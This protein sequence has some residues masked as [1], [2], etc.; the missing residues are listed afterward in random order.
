MAWVM[1]RLGLY[2]FGL[3]TAAYQE[4]NR[5][6]A[7]RWARQERMGTNDAL[8]FTGIGPE[9]IDLRGVIFPEFRGGLRQI[10]KMRQQASLGMP[11]PLI[12]GLGKVWGLW[13]IEQ[14]GERQSVFMARGAPKRIEFDLRLSRYDG[15][16][17]A[18]LPFTA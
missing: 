3:D 10:G 15:G 5:V 9:T 2:K 8:Q 6:A 1:M 18:L 7:Y 12:D 16:L 13:V 17:R 11:L 14:I 4:L